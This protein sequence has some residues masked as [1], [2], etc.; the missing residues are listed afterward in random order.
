MEDFLFVLD[1]VRDSII[2]SLLLMVIN[3]PR[4]KYETKSFEIIAHETTVQ[5]E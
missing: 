4:N 1:F 3:A 2:S 5:C